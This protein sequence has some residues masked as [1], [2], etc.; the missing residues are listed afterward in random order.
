VLQKT[1]G[2]KDDLEQL[3]QLCCFLFNGKLPIHKVIKDHLRQIKIKNL[4]DFVQEY[5]KNNIDNYH[6]SVKEML[7]KRFQTAYCYITSLNYDSKPEYTLVKFWL[8]SNTD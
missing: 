7:P 4:F 3:M 8:A 2:R 1:L 6:I 5:R